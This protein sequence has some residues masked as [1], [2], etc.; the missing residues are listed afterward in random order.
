VL[1]VD[2]TAESDPD[3]RNLF[4]RLGTKEWEVSEI[5]RLVL[6]LHSSSDFK[7]EALSTSELI[8][9]AVFLWKSSWQP[10]KGTDIWFG[11]S[12]GK[13]CRGRELYIPGGTK[14]GSAAARIFACLQDQFAI[15]HGDYLAV[16]GDGD[17]T[18]WLIRNLGL[19][20][21]PRLVTPQVELKP[22][23]VEIIVPQPVE[24][25][26]P[27]PVKVLKDQTDEPPKGQNFM[28]INGVS[29][30]TSYSCHLFLS[31]WRQWISRWASLIR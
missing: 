19:M 25:I 3:R 29:S 14:K 5:C 17:W 15:L 11:T 23:P 28:N 16:S 8:S 10:A 27:Q 24:I 13:R 9:H 26:E 18:E 30:H 2:S 20:K 21:I 1:V 12:R 22:Q 4:A 6:E 31:L 7:P